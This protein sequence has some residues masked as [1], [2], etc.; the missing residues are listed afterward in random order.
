VDALVEVLAPDATSF[1]DGGGKAPSTP[2]PL[3]GDVR[4][5]KA[6]IGWGRKVRERGITHR[7]ALVNGQ[8]GLV[9][10]NPDGTVRWV[11]A[12]EIADGV[13]VAVR[14]ILNPD[15]LTHVSGG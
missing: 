14:S 5:A 1:G 7:R 2:E 6:L 3:V 10:L 12:L 15:K 4:V 13:V 11:A 8:P 9:F